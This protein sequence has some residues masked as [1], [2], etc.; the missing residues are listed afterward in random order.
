M[1]NWIESIGPLYGATM[2]NDEE[3]I[4]SHGMTY[5]NKGM[6]GL[7]LRKTKESNDAA[8]AKLGWRY[9]NDSEGLWARVLKGKY[10]RDQLGVNLATPRVGNSHVWKGLYE[11]WRKVQKGASWILGDGKSVPFWTDRWVIDKPLIELAIAS[12]DQSLS[13]KLVADY[14]GEN[15][16]WRWP[17][18]D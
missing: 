1:R 5:V 12:I 17:E 4:W 6:G 14:W 7:G 2:R 15:G 13:T 3:C 18:F 16:E 11:S 9:L 10:S 8:L